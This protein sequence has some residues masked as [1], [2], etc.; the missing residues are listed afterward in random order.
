MLV[1]YGGPTDAVEVPAANCVAVRGEPVEVPDEVGKSLL[2]QDTWSEV[3]AK[4][5]AENKKD[6]DV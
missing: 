1:V 6:G 5:K 4:P 3:K 2:E